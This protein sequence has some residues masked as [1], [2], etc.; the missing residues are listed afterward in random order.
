MFN[1]T[2]DLCCVT[3]VYKLKPL[4]RRAEFGL[5]LLFFVMSHIPIFGDP[6]WMNTI[7][8]LMSNKTIYQMRRK[9]SLTFLF[10]QINFTGVITGLQ[11]SIL[12]WL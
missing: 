2:L 6:N 7:E 10:P 11:C 5:H 9:Q 8:A 4:L 3:I 12:Q 1:P